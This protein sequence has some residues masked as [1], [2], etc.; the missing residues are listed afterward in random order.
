[1]TMGPGRWHLEEGSSRKLRRQVVSIFR[2]G[3][4]VIFGSIELAFSSATDN[5]RGPLV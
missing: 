5:S 1:M 2:I 3:S 4:G